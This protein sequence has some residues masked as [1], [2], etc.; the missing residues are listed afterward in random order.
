MSMVAGD[1]FACPPRR[2]ASASGV[3]AS[4][5]F[6]LL[7]VLALIALARPFRFNEPVEETIDLQIV[8]AV[9]AEPEP[10][11]QPAPPSASPPPA[12]AA[13]T[14]QPGM[15]RATTMLSAKVLA[16]P[17]SRQTREALPTLELGTRLEQIC[18]LEAVAQVAQWDKSFKPDRVIAYAMASTKVKSGIITAPGA[19]MRSGGNWYN[20]AFNCGI[21]PETQE[22]QSF[23]FTVGKP[24][25]REAWA[26]HALAPVY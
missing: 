5:V 18:N 6:H 25:P 2:E 26:D 23:E 16:D 9:P 1:I 21:S 13:A 20:L 3:I 10:A 22:V 11:S 24:I 17:R 14:E 7:L 19:A 4:A 12:A 8:P 15:H